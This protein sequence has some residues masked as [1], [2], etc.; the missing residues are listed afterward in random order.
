MCA[1][2][3]RDGGG[4]R[5]LIQWREPPSSAAGRSS[6]VCCETVCCPLLPAARPARRGLRLQ[7]RTVARG[8]QWFVPALR[9]API[10]AASTGI[11]HTAS[12]GLGRIAS[13]TSGRTV[14]C[15]L[16]RSVRLGIRVRA[17]RSDGP[18]SSVE[19]GQEGRRPRACPGSPIDFRLLGHRDFRPCDRCLGA[20]SSSWPRSAFSRRL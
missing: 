3:D 19:A 4:S 18:I 12:W 14:A 15:T 17:K 20:R 5:C 13:V 9:S 1:A 11:G 6:R 8:N 2:F 16:V 10:R 7:T